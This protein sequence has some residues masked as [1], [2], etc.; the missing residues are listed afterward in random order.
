MSQ[1]GVRCLK[2]GQIAWMRAIGEVRCHCDS[3]SIGLKEF[4]PVIGH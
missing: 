1:I 3:V 4:K 2:C